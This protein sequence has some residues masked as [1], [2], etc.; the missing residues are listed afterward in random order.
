MRRATEKLYSAN[1]IAMNSSAYEV[2]E[3]ED[4]D[5]AEDQ[6]QNYLKNVRESALIRKQNEQYEKM[7]LSQTQEK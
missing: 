2:D 4:E 3:D 5:E 7:L 1:L 6:A